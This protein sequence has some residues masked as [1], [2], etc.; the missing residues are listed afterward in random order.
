MVV[1]N[2]VISGLSG[3]FST[4]NGRYVLTDE[5]DQEYRKQDYDNAIDIAVFLDKIQI[6]QYTNIWKIQIQQH[7]NIWKMIFCTEQFLKHF[8]KIYLSLREQHD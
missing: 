6:Q 1:E 8:P 4:V 7:T 2:L 3:P 5:P